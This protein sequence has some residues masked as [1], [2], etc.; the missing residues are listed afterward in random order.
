MGVRGFSQ[1]NQ[2]YAAEALRVEKRKSSRDAG[3]TRQAK[4]LHAHDVETVTKSKN[5]THHSVEAPVCQY[6]SVGAVFVGTL[7]SRRARTF[8]D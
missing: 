1:A 2:P 6:S 8:D 4:C 3:D 7:G 5:K